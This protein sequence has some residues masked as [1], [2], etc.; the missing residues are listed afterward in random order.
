MI[1]SARVDIEI[2]NN[3][4]WND[5]FQFGTLGDT[6]WSFTGQSFHIDIKA[7]R[8]DAAALLSLTTAN[9]RVVVDDY[10]NRILHFNVDY[11]TLQAAL[12]IGEYQYDLCMV[13]TSVPPVRVPLM[14]GEVKIR[15]G[16]TQS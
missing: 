9:G 10:V 2:A 12:P 13:D 5:A 4:T 3:Q 15:Q 7:D 6:T 1:T 8:N 14:H 16:V 11:L